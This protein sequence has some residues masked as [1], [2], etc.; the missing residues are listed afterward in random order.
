MKFKDA[1]E[2][3]NKNKELIGKKFKGSTID[4]IIINSTNNQQFK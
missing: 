4:E 3:A 2:L 1:L